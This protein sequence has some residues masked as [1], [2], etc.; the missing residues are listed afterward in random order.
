[1]PAPRRRNISVVKGSGTGKSEP[2]TRPT[3]VSGSRRM[4]PRWKISRPV[5][6][7]G[8]PAGSRLALCRPRAGIAQSANGC[9]IW[10][11]S[12]GIFLVV[13]CEMRKSRWHQLRDKCQKA[14]RKLPAYLTHEYKQAEN[15]RRR[16]KLRARRMMWWTNWRST[17]SKKGLTPV[18]F[19]LLWLEQNG[20]CQICNTKPTKMRKQL[21]IDHDHK[22]GRVRGLL[23]NECNFGLGK[24]QDNSS[25][26]RN[27]A[28]YVE[29]F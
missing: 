7:T 9:S 11:A 28:S 2:V 10:N 18:K 26:L 22:T 19:A 24:F 1:M 15:H 5:A 21:F 8:G 12:P 4:R 25:L 3:A 20:V 14:G 16:Q 6:S 29:G 17:L 13:D 23:C 27:A